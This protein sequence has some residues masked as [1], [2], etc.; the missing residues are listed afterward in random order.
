LDYSVEIAVVGI[1]VADKAK[2]LYWI[3]AGDHGLTSD[4]LAATVADIREE[5]QDVKSRLSQLVRLLRD[6]RQ[7]IFT[8]TFPF[9]LFCLLLLI[10]LKITNALE[11]AKRAIEEEQQEHQEEIRQRRA[12]TINSILTSFMSLSITAIGRSVSSTERMRLIFLIP[13]LLSFADGAIKQWSQY[14]HDVGGGVFTLIYYIP[15]SFSSS[16]SARKARKVV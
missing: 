4:A 5:A 16:Y 10:N 7:G 8:V 15:S 12:S 6:N 9:L 13:P 1:G 2:D 3:L 14:A 11:S